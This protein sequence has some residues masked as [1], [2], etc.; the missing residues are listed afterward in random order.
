MQTEA[1][2]ASRIVEDLLELSE[3]ESGVERDLHPVAL[4][5]VMHDAAGR[6][7]ELASRGE[8]E[9]ETI[10]PR[11][12]I[13][14][15]EPTDSAHRGPVVTGDRHQ[16]ASAVGNMVENAVKYSEPGDV[17]HVAVRDEGGFGE[18][19]VA[20]EGAGIPRADL[21]RVFERFYR[22]DRPRSRGTGG[23]GLGLS[24]VRHV[25]Q[26]HGGSISV[27]SVEGQGATFVLRLPLARNDADGPADPVA[28]DT[29]ERAGPTAP[30]ERARV[31]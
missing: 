28:D 22:V 15:S 4:I 19:V 17:V 21:Y 18:I 2:R 11:G 14:P 8:I 9:I 30:D 25:A 31:V 1:Q 20:D 10:E 26:A 7:A 5:D 27:D 16:L 6:V 29:P 3:I 12:S 23:T 24:I 13:E